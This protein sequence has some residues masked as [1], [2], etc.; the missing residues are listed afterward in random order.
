MKKL[1]S[2]DYVI[3]KYGKRVEGLD[4]IYSAETIIDM[5]NDGVESISNDEQFVR[6]T[7]LPL[8]MQKDY[9]N[10]LNESFPN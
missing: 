7:D 1:Y 10:K 8:V 2:T 4:V 9:L 3:L 6:M 5:L